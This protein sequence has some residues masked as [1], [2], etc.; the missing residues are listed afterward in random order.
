MRWLLIYLF[1]YLF[2]YYRISWSVCCSSF[3]VIFNLET[4][5]LIVG[6]TPI[7]PVPQRCDLSTMYSLNFC[8]YCCSGSL[9]NGILDVQYA[10][11]T[12]C[13]DGASRLHLITIQSLIAYLL[14]VRFATHI[15]WFTSIQRFE[16][17]KIMTNNNYM[18]VS[19]VW[20]Y[21]SWRYDHESYLL[22]WLWNIKVKLWSLSW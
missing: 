19:P 17:M 8:Q 12:W 9:C 22:N 1:V 5:N 13:Y 7:T 18:K 6:C 15:L 2:I 4:T 11:E 10:R 14:L 3:Q 20:W 21:E 16:N